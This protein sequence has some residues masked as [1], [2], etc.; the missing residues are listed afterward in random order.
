M[1]STRI[2][3]SLV[4]AHEGVHSRAGDP[5]D[6]RFSPSV[7][8]NRA[9]PSSVAAKARSGRILWLSSEHV[10][11]PRGRRFATGIGL[12]DMIRLRPILGDK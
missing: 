6:G 10:F 11:V 4:P 5:F 3:P 1:I 9:S 2:E 7:A 8:T 12:D